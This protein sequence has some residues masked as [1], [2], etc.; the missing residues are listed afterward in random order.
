MSRFDRI[1]EDAGAA[2]SRHDDGSQGPPLVFGLPDGEWVADGIYKMTHRHGL[3]MPHGARAFASPDDVCVM[4]TFGATEKVV[5][6]DLE[7]TGLSGGSGTY[8]FLCALGSVSGADFIVEQ[9][10]LQGPSKERAWL[11]AIESAIP[12]NA[13][14]V[15]YN[16]ASFDMPMLAARAVMRRFDP[17]WASLPHIDLLRL[18]R[19]FYR[20]R[21]ASCSLGSI[22]R[23]VL[24]LYRTDDDI[25]GH[26]IP[27]IYMHY[28]HTH[29]ASPLDGVFYHNAIDII[30]LA[31]LYVKIGEML[32]GI[33][34]SAEDLMYASDVWD[35]VGCPERRDALLEKACA[36]DAASVGA[37]FRRAIINKRRQLWHESI[38]DLYGTLDALLN[39]GD[40]WS[41]GVSVYMVCEEIAKI[42]EH[43]LRTPIEA[44]KHVEIAYEW[45]KHGSGRIGHDHKRMLAELIRRRERLDRKIK[46]TVCG[47]L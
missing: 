32:D 16:G 3:S 28:L 8:A 17:A 45:L 20:S 1:F 36:L 33:S 44:M 14:I 43:R 19:R 30:S 22:E 23:H 26:M 31:A 10:F 37:R 7:T 4:R 9:F 21:L 12:T 42:A 18:A 2:P 11:E 47:D 34:E 38:A 41:D 24:G 6:L 5:F 15:T 29:D 25:P 40:G 27:A 39:G 35:S 13:T 46:R